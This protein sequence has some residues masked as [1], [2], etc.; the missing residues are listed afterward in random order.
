MRFQS[1][2]RRKR[3]Q[4]D[5]CLVV[6]GFVIIH[7]D[8]VCESRNLHQIFL[9]RAENIRM[10]CVNSPVPFRVERFHCDPD[11]CGAI[12]P[13]SRSSSEPGVALTLRNGPVWSDSTTVPIFF[14]LKKKKNK[15]K[16][17]LGVALTPRDGPVWSV[18]TKRVCDH[19]KPV[20]P[21]H[22]LE[23]R[24]AVKLQVVRNHFFPNWVSSRDSDP[25]ARGARAT[26]HVCHGDHEA[27]A[28]QEA[29]GRS[30]TNSLACRVRQVGPLA[31]W[32]GRGVR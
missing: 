3:D 15:K 21:R 20:T 32:C 12:P 17:E 13:Q 5:R 25:S 7:P 4:L 30:E 28:V 29:I 19:A 8:A 6:Q 24:V 23:S 18:S 14:F 2:K 9:Y 1:D 11:Q 26:P 31:R 27:V 22:C 16:K 10:S